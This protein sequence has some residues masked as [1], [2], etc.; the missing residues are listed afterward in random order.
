MPRNAVV[1]RRRF[2]TPTMEWVVA[3]IVILAV[4]AVIFVVFG[5]VRS[6]TTGAPL[7]GATVAADATL[8]PI[9]SMLAG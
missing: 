9:A 4:L 3:G 5:D 1:G 7:D 6:T 2:L 8:P